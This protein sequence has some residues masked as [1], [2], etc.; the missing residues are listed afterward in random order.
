MIYVF[1][2][3]YGWIQFA[4]CFFRIFSSQHGICL[5]TLST[6]AE[7]THT[8]DSVVSLRNVHTQ[9]CLLKTLIRDVHKTTHRSQSLETI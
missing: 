3:V 6:K 8:Y 1:T 4:N 2:Y 5:P 7:T 9:T